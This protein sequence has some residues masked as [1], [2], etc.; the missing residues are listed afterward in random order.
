[1]DDARP[2]AVFW[3]DFA[4][5]GSPSGAATPIPFGAS[6]VD[7]EGIT[8]DGT[9]VYVVGSQS[10][11]RRGGAGLVRFRLDGGAHRASPVETID[12][13]GSLL[14]HALPVGATGA[15]KRK[16]GPSLNVEGLA[17]DAK[18]ARLLLGLRAPLAAGRAQVVP[19]TLREP[20]GPFTAANLGVGP[21]IPLDLGGSGIRG[22]EEDG[23]GGFWVIAGGVQG[24]GTSRLVR[25]DGR[26][27]SVKDVATFP[28]DLKPEG[29][30]PVKVAGRTAT[31]VLCDTS[32]YVF[33]DQARGAAAEPVSP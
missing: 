32:R 14:A 1:V 2:D 15:E 23:T 13:L 7:P 10:R 3:M 11:G 5:D 4:P 19:V 8:T 26:G 18:A 6:V 20:S 22:I 17:W 31:L 25:W 9:Y 33:V 16:G 30:A 27:P 24:A 12:D 29:V 28:A 21:P